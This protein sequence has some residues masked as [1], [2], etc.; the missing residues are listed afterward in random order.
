M[1]NKTFKLR[2][3]DSVTVVELIK[4]VIQTKDFLY[5]CTTRGATGVVKDDINLTGRELQL[6]QL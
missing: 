4:K 1:M 5:R 3:G 2:D 6:N